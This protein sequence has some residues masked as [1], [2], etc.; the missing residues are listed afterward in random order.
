[1]L[2]GILHINRYDG[3]R[4][5][6]E[7]TNGVVRDR[8]LRLYYQSSFKDVEHVGAICLKL[9]SLADNLDGFFS[10]WSPWSRTYICGQMKLKRE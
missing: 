7:V 8:H 2:T 3:T 5:D 6:I 10:G 9:S 4:A 1:M